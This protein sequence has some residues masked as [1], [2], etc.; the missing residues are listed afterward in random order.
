MSTAPRRILVVDDDPA[1]RRLFEVLLGG[2]GNLCTAV[3][4]AE[5]GLEAAEEHA[6]DLA[7]FD[8]HLPGMSGAEAAFELRRR[9]EDLPVIAVSGHLDK[10]DVDDL[11]D[12]GIGKVLAKPFKRDDLL[13]AVSDMLEERSGR[14]ASAE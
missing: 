1:I 9:H 7:I 11:H 13:L 3:G 12:L 5:D 2:E 6:F 4:T 8:L 10:W 14:A